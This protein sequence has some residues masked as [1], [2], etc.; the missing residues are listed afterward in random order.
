MGTRRGGG[1][2]TAREREVARLVGLGLTNRE[3]AQRLRISDRTV[4]AHIQNLLN[5]LAANNRAQI[6]AWSAQLSEAPARSMGPQTVT[7][8]ASAAVPTRTTTPRSMLV[9]AGLVLCLVFP[10]DHAIGRPSAAAG[11]SIE[12]GDPVFDAQFQADGHEFGLR[13]L[14]GDPDASAVK[15]VNGGLEYSVL[16]PGGNTGNRPG[17]EPMPAF[18]AEYELSVR[19]KTNVEFW[20]NFS[21]DDPSRYPL[22]QIVIETAIEAMQ[23]AYDTGEPGPSFPLGPQVSIDRLLQ[24]R[25]FTISTLV[26]P[27]V[28]R[29]FLDGVRV[30]DVRHESVRRLQSPSFA[31][32][33]DGG[34][35]RL[36]ALRVY[37]VGISPT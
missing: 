7:P 10:A 9:A 22:H 26:A 19:P 31:I 20:I 5:K 17:V 25:V 23:L 13:Y 37:K 4:G 2:P 27:P 8:P 36:S 1:S 21:A 3:I 6:A 30:I 11:V 33:G 35:V 29:V 24:G 12:H 28:Y 34:T 15:F 14:S 32:F 18:F 16:K